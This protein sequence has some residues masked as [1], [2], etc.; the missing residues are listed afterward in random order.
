MQPT[1][2]QPPRPELYV[3][4]RAAS[5]YELPEGY[6]DAVALFNEASRD[7]QAKKPEKAAPKFI[8]VAEL[9]KAP[10]SKTTYST[11]FA[12]MRAASY[13]DAAI[14]FGEAGKKSDGKKALQGAIAS[15]PENAELLREL[16]GMMN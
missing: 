5:R 16:V 11:Q 13:R 7:Y 14:T 10:K 12:K 15:D 1:L 8:K 9:L 3:M 6:E 4:P 2:I